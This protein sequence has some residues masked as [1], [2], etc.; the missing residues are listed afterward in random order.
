MTNINTK[1]PVTLAETRI[2]II[3]LGL[4]GGSLAMALRGHCRACFAYDPDSATIERALMNQ[5]VDH[6]SNDPVEILADID[7]VI[8]AAP[9][10]AILDWIARIPSLLPSPTII[11]DLGS[12]KT[13]ICDAFETLPPRFDPIGGH[14]M[15]GKEKNGLEN[16]EGS[17]YHHA[18]FAL[19][20]LLRTS[21]HARSIALEIVQVVGSKE[22]WIDPIIHDRYAA[23]TSHTP[24]LISS[25]LSLATSVEATALSGPGFI[26]TTRLAASS[27]SLMIDILSTNQAN[28]L[29]SLTNFRGQLDRLEIL[30]RKNNLVDLE[31]VLKNSAAHVKKFHG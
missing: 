14:P 16:A 30:L 8:L 20:P 13:Q 1:H 10:M 21:S 22:L 15:T 6:A 4:M 18:T 11:M 2:A 26:S 9:V 12:T 29:E 19:S 3:G 27:P 5:I 25:A 31:T 24:Y 7:M 28:L 17:L 23:A